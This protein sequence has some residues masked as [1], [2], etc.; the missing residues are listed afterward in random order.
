MTDPVL[1]ED[2]DERAKN[3][4]TSD[5]DEADQLRKLVDALVGE[6]QELEQVFYALIVEQY[7]NSAVGDQLDRYGQI[8][9]ELRAGLSDA[10]YRGFIRARIK[11]NQGESE[12]DRL[13]EVVATISGAQN[14]RY[15]PTVPASY[16]LII[17]VINALDEGTQN[18]IFNQI[19]QLTPAGVG[20]TVV[21][22]E[23]DG[24]GFKDDPRSLGFGEGVFAS[25]VGIDG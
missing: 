11:T 4:L 9:G 20:T 8:V 19:L 25:V 14:V 22:A 24:F 7:L 3:L 15:I 16:Q 1:I 5:F 12:I 13:L 18:R 21:Q 10:D 17:E 23:V 6:V 2:H